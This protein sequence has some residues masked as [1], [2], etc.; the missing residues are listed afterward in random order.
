MKRIVS[1]VLCLAVL[2]GTLLLSSC[3]WLEEL[4]DAAGD[5]P[6]LGGGSESENGGTGSV[7]IDGS[8]LSA[9][10]LY[11]AAK[12]YGYQGSFLDF[13]AEYF[14]AEDMGGAGSGAT[15]IEGGISKAILSCV[16]VQA[17]FRQSGFYGSTYGSAGSG[18]IYKLDKSNGSAYLITNYHVVYDADSKAADGISTDIRVWLYGMLSSDAGIKATYIG[19]SMTYDIAVLKIENSDILRESDARAVTVADSNYVTVGNQAVAIGNPE[20]SGISAT[21]GIVS[22][23]SEYITMTA[24]DGR[25]SVNMRVMRVDTPVNSGNSGGGLFDATGRMIGI[26]NAKIVD[27]STENIGYAIPSNIATYVAESIIENYNDNDKDTFGVTKCL[28]GVTVRVTDSRAVYDRETGSTYVKETV[29][30]VDVMDNYPADGRLEAGDVLVS[31]EV[32]DEIYELSRQFIMTD[33]L[34]T[35]RAGSVLKL[36]VLRDGAERSFTVT[37]DEEY[38]TEVE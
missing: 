24:A 26:V 28:L 4:K 33:I 29:S 1:I 35:C 17:V 27:T 13:V 18:V 12:E 20:N 38:I 19:G 30:V 23:D 16:S 25:T 11:E 22:V 14:S 3:N 36:N 34:L 2:C 9:E 37:L 15:S 8:S 32:D 7:Y 10:E 21:A 31:V 6:S 5:R